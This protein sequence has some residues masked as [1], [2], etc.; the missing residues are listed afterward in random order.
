MTI[1]LAILVILGYL[2]AMFITIR[3]AGS[4][5]KK[6]WQAGLICTIAVLVYGS[7]AGAAFVALQ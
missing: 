5:C 2:L 6:L 4:W 1:M 3:L 7:A